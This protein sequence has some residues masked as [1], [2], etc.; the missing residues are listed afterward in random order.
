VAL[1]PTDPA[2]GCALYNANSSRNSPLGHNAGAFL[3]WG[4]LQDLAPQIGGQ[5]LDRAPR[6]QIKFKSFV[7]VY[8]STGILGLETRGQIERRDGKGS[9]LRHDSGAPLPPREAPAEPPPPARRGS[10]RRNPSRAGFRTSETPEHPA[11]QR[12][13]FRDPLM[14]MLLE[15]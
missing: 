12:P 11:T 6:R 8:A 13:A 9:I 15:D 7:A 3:G 1:D 4:E 10:D 2:L 14:A 5:Y